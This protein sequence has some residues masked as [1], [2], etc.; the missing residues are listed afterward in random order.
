MF[1]L[2]FAIGKF[3]MVVF[4]PD[5]GTCEI[6]EIKHSKEVVSQ[7]CKHMLDEQNGKEMTLRLRLGRFFYG[8]EVKMTI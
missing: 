1:C 2:Q 5:E 8:K 6:Y 4:N 7:Q 3:D